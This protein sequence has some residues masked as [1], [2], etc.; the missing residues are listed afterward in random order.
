MNIERAAACACLAVVVA[1]GGTAPRPAVESRP[2]PA[3]E[4]PAP[5]KPVQHPV[6]KDTQEAMALI[7]EAIDAR[8]ADIERCV[9]G[10]RAR[11]GDPHA[12]V[13]LK[14]GI[15]QEGTLIGLGTAKASESDAESV[16]C[17]RASLR[18][19]PF[20][21]SKAGVITVVRAFDIVELKRR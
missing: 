7:N 17:I 13:S 5:E 8:Q 4:A 9:E 14:L 10:F 11:K 16:E 20:P 15:D 1:C 2:T 3:S 6:A 12:R 19:A 21:K 18:R